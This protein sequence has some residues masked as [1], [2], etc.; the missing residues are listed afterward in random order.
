MTIKQDILTQLLD[1]YKESFNNH[2]E[3]EKYKWIAV[4]SFQ[5]N[6]NIEAADF[7]S[8]L[9]RAMKKTTNLLA[10]K[11]NYPLQMLKKFATV[12]PNETKQLFI[13]LFN[14]SLDLEKR[15][16]DFIQGA[17][18]IRTNYNDGSWINHYQ[19]T[20]SISTY[21]WLKYPD[22][23]YIYKYS[24]IQ[25]VEKLLCEKPQIKKGEGPKNLL[26]ANQLLDIVSERLQKDSDF[27]YMLEQKI[28]DDCY[29]DPYLKTM[30]IDFEFHVS[31]YYE[32]FIKK[33][34]K[35]YWLYAP[36]D[37]AKYWDEF[38]T[39]GIIGI[40]WEEI[41]DLSEFP[42]RSSIKAEMDKKYGTDSSHSNSVQITWDFANEMNIGDV[43]FVK[44]GLYKVLGYGIITS[45]YYFDDKREEYNNVRKV[46]WM[47]K[48]VWNHPGQAVQKT[49]TNITNY[50]DYVNKLQKLFTMTSELS[51]YQSLLAHKKNIILQGAP[52]V[53]KTYTTA[54]L[55]LSIC[56]ETIPSDHEEVMN[57]Y[58]ELQ[59]EGRIGF[60]TFHQSMDYEDFVEGI[61]PR[62]ID[63]DKMTYTIEDGIFKKLCNKAQQKKEGDIIKCIDNYIE[64]IKG[65]NNRKVI[66]TLTSKSSLYVWWNPGNATLSTRSSYSTSSKD[67]EYTPSPINIEKL[68]MQAIGEGI[69]NNWPSYAQAI[70]NAIQNEYKNELKTDNSNTPYVLIIDE[71]NRGNVS[72]IFGELITL[73][74][75]DKRIGG[76]H[77]LKVTL[78]Y[79]KTEFG[80]PTNLYIIGTMNTTD[81]SVGNIDYAVRRR[82]AFVTLKSDKEVVKQKSIPQA[83]KLFE[84][85]ETFIKKNQIEM[86]FED[87]MVGHSYFIA[88]NETEL[89]MK[90]DYEIIPLLREYYKDGLLKQDVTPETTIPQFVGTWRATSLP[91]QPTETQ[92]A[93]STQTI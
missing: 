63:E 21:L 64:S 18:N 22:K 24:E 50:S 25:P 43:V 60:V 34:S 52:G 39:S 65:Y 1:F 74:E 47:Q 93:A 90:W 9:D 15:V 78:P 41:G 53:G 75:A 76:N 10:S 80:V 31:R 45:N 85:V 46:K 84:A 61:K 70:I 88:E 7:A 35:K 16:N 89:K 86:D 14:E 83:L 73:L 59:K 8:M 30:T 57:R 12:A 33:H 49:L 13:E 58:E 68:K 82:F 17:E 5:D 44:Q 79:S 92:S 56:G 91:N 36:G 4:K 20:N 51:V 72:K 69:E 23:Y 28:N 71:I 11:N 67:P 81:R 66:P 54:A 37:N 2:W 19:V 40:G 3:E 6:W 26:I 38:Y 32:S 48:G 55:A 62:I 27:K 87:L 77:P 29:S 42:N